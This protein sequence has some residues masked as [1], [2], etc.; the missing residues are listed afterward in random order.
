MKI[1]SLLLLQCKKVSC[2][3]EN[4]LVPK[5]SVIDIVLVDPKEKELEFLDAQAE[6]ICSINNEQN[7]FVLMM[8]IESIRETCTVKSTEFTDSMFTTIDELEDILAGTSVISSIGEARTK[9]L[10]S[11]LLSSRIESGVLACTKCNETY[12][13]TNG[14]IDFVQKEEAL[15]S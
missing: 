5:N 6:T 8:V 2:R 10:F 7:D 9:A 1:F 3:M 15:G 13:I 12:P 4:S 14:I 11:L